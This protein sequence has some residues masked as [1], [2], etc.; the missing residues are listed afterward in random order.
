MSFG[1]VSCGE[2]SAIVPH[3][4]LYPFDKNNFKEFVSTEAIHNIMNVSSIW[5]TYKYLQP[6]WWVLSQQYSNQKE[7]KH[8]PHK[9]YHPLFLDFLQIKLAVCVICEH[10]YVIRSVQNLCIQ[11]LKMI[12]N[13]F[14]LV[15][16]CHQPACICYKLL[17]KGGG[18]I[19][20]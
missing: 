12:K 17:K 3:S 13:N 18:G 4:F 10:M 11:E 1:L 9:L 16:S 19:V 15:Y 8:Y 5:Q 6:L 2:L 7:K 20:T 14:F